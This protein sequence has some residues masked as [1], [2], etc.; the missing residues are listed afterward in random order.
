MALNQ[1]ELQEGVDEVAASVT[2]LTQEFK[3]LNDRINIPNPEDQAAIDAFGKKL[4]T[5]AQALR[6]ISPDTPTT[7]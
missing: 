4:K 2:E 1:K 6:D 7:T 5:V 3:D